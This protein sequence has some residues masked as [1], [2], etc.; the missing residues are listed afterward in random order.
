VVHW[1]RRRMRVH[2]VAHRRENLAQVGDSVV[3]LGANRTGERGIGEFPMVAADSCRRDSVEV[4][5]EISTDWRRRRTLPS[6]DNAIARSGVQGV[7]RGRLG[8]TPTST[9]A[10]QVWIRPLGL[11]LF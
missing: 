1:S 3:D 11:P 6:L 2:Y 7:G 5:G 10:P 9:D 8:A 4:S